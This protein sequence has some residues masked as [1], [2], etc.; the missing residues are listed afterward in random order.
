MY[1]VIDVGGTFI[2]YGYYSKDGLCQ[3]NGKIKTPKTNLDEFYSILLSLKKENLDGVAIS[4]PGLLDSHTGDV[5]AISLLP[6]LASHNVK[7][8]L[9]DLFKL[10]VSIEND[11]KCAALGEMWKGNLQ[12]IQNGL[13]IVLGSG[14]GGTIIQDG[15]IIKSPRHKAGEIGSILMPKDMSYTKM[16]NFGA[17][18]SANHLIQEISSAI[19]CKNDG[20]EVF[21]K[22]KSDSKAFH[23]F[24]DYCR[25]IAF[26][27]YNLDYILDLDVV[28]LGGGISEQD[29][30]IS[31]VQ[32]E[33]SK[34]RNQY[35]EDNHEPLITVCLHHNE[36]NLLGTLYHHF[37]LK[38]NKKE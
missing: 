36:A 17:N 13:F 32:E 35:K 34:L 2:K 30:F 29:I 5:F 38:D 4:M 6:F 11:A 22:I 26:M 8:E 28:C 33:F 18:N 16:T 19:G 25:Q 24:Q 23:I 7:K 20:Y 1:L 31:T 9:E 12:N 14:I 21:E 37:L 27:I 10:P 3:E 15:K